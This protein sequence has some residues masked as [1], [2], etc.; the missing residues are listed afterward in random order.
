MGTAL[1][2]SFLKILQYHDASV[3]TFLIA[4]PALFLFFAELITM[5]QLICTNVYVDTIVIY[6]DLLIL[7]L[8]QISRSHFILIKMGVFQQRNF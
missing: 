6:I 2:Q 7:I 4:D 5:L 8:F 1:H 3:Q